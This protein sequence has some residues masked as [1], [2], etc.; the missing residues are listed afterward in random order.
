MGRTGR[1][2]DPVAPMGTAAG[3]GAGR[4]GLRRGGVALVEGLRGDACEGHVAESEAHAL[5]VEGFN[6]PGLA[7]QEAPDAIRA[8]VLQGQHLLLN[9]E[10][11]GEG[12]REYGF[13]Y[14][15]RVL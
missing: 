9:L 2:L 14:V 4:P 10:K 8:L 5:R 13:P 6:L 3:D 11:G 1:V 12:G 7:L 15:N